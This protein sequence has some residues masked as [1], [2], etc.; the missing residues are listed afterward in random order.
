MTWPPV[1]HCYKQPHPTTNTGRTFMSCTGHG[2]MSCTV[3][4]FFSTSYFRH[5]RSA[6]GK[7]QAPNN[8]SD[9]GRY[10]MPQRSPR[11]GTVLALC[12]AGLL[13]SSYVVFGF[14]EPHGTLC[15]TVIPRFWTMKWLSGQEQDARRKQRSSFRWDDPTAHPSHVL[16]SNVAKEDLR[17]CHPCSPCVVPDV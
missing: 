16:P 5:P 12:V 10:L 14:W 17:L 15:W 4:Q 3:G 1:F 9:G 11:L 8:F 6:A 13:A 7:N 2:E